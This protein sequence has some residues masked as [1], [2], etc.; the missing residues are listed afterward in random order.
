MTRNYLAVFDFAQK[1]LE[2][3]GLCVKPTTHRAV[4]IIAFGNVIF[5]HLEDLIHI[6][7]SICRD[8]APS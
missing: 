7:E 2:L 8:H 4:V 6:V 5:A 3:K 1:D